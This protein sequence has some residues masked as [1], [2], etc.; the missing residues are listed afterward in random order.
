[1]SD[2]VEVPVEQFTSS[3]IHSPKSTEDRL[4]KISPECVPKLSSSLKRPH[5]DSSGEAPSNESL[6]PSKTT[7]SASFD[8]SSQKSSQNAD[9]TNSPP[10]PKQRHI[11]NNSQTLQFSSQSN[12]ITTSNSQEKLT[13]TPG[14]FPI[15]STALPDN[16]PFARLAQTTSLPNQSS[17]KNVFGGSVPSKTFGSTTSSSSNSKPIFGQSATFGS[18]SGLFEGASA[19]TSDSNPF[20]KMASATS[21]NLTNSGLGWLKKKTVPPEEALEGADSLNSSQNSNQSAN[22]HE[23]ESGGFGD[24]DHLE[25]FGKTESKPNLPEVQV[26]TGEESDVNVL[27]LN[28]KCYLFCSETR[29]W[30]ER[31]TGP[32]K[33]NDEDN[34]N[35]SGDRA[36][37]SKSRLIMRGNGTHRLILNTPLWS[38]MSLDKAGSKSI[39][40]SAKHFETGKVHIYLVK[41]SNEKEVDSLYRA[42]KF[43]IRDLK[44]HEET[45]KSNDTTDSTNEKFEEECK[46]NEVS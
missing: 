3:P 17:T 23:E 20:G 22:H 10:N 40:L 18:S 35:G 4:P 32:I 15:P 13:K 42:I 39:R 44:S 38:T 16:N 5:A 28:G 43:R 8:E 34:S 21:S 24:A 25:Q 12:D 29:N 41:S 46:V 2:T 37:F 1:M 26:N 27:S 11:E 6:P 31:G 33:L 14:G 7:K 19:K 30:L 36:S 45:L 9:T